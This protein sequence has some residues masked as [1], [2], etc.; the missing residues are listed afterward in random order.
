MDNKRI[1]IVLS[2]DLKNSVIVNG[3]TWDEVEQLM[4]EARKLYASL[5]EEFG[6][7]TYGNGSQK[8]G[9]SPSRGSAP[10]SKGGSVSCADCGVEIAGKTNF[11]TKQF[12]SGATRAEF[13]VKTFG[14]P[15]CLN[16][17]NGCYA[18]AK[19]NGESV[20]Y[21]KAG[22]AKRRAASRPENELDF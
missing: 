19:A 4:P 17:Q 14:R 11:K 13:G 6:I 7:K 2:T 18:A 16:D 20:D 8:K 12:E 21:S 9:T 1:G 5:I 3:E 22:A 10:T 15:L